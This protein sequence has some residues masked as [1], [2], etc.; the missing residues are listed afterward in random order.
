MGSLG[1]PEAAVFCFG[2]AVSV[3]LGQN[4]RGMAPSPLLVYEEKESICGLTSSADLQ[5]VLAVGATKEAVG[6]LEP[7][8]P[9]WCC[10]LGPACTAASAKLCTMCALHFGLW[11]LLNFCS[12]LRLSDLYT[13]LV[14]VWFLG[15]GLS[16]FS[17]PGAFS[18][19]LRPAAAHWYYP[20]NFS[21]STACST[22][23]L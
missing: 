7:V 15:V 4:S 3:F 11:S 21:A 18:L 8:S 5:V 17:A 9:T 6:C 1:L 22:L 14:S 16:Q 13:G 20:G 23:L 19:Y 12:R 2:L 10:R